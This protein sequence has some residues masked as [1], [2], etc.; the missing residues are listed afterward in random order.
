MTLFMHLMS[1]SFFSV[2]CT[3]HELNVDFSRA[4]LPRHKLCISSMSS[5]SAASKRLRE[6]QEES[7]LFLLMF[8]ELTQERL[9][10]LNE[11]DQ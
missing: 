1:L 6:I 5:A 2:A 11:G 4:L 3:V 7:A 8:H 10:L 9:G